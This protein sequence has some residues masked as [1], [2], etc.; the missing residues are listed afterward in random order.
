MPEFLQD[1]LALTAHRG[2]RTRLT[3]GHH[4]T[5]VRFMHRRNSSGRRLL[6]R[7]RTRI[8]QFRIAI[9]F[10]LSI[11]ALSVLGT[12]VISFL[13]LCLLILISLLSV[14]IVGLELLVAFVLLLI[15]LISL[16]F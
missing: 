16:N 3:E 14:L 5:F 1:G 4:G 9:S 13:I 6:L 11:D 15:R 12:G 2:M 8:L 10:V 7:A